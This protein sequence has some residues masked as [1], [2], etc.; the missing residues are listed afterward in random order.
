[1]AIF[2][3]RGLK[4]RLGADYTF[5]LMARLYPKISA[6]KILKT[7]E[8]LQSIPSL[9]TF[10]IGIT[11]FYLHLDS[12]QIV[13]CTIAASILGTMITIFGV[14]IIPALPTLSTLYS[15]VCGFGIFLT[16][17]VSYGMLSVGWKGTLAFLL[18]QLTGW[19][20]NEGIDLWHSK[21][22]YS[23]TQTPFTLSE[24]NFLN[25]YRLHADKIGITRDLSVSEQELKEENW[26]QCFNDL[27]LS[28]PKI[29][30]RFTID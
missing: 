30:A 11:A 3:P 5:A 29:V 1:M 10:I 18:G 26:D 17:I 12:L 2:T 14:F 9:L 21:R 23:K 13:L 15:H 4:I 16:I 7:A 22:I 20:I 24:I 28:Y 6:F 8:G 25:A 27:Y 19:I